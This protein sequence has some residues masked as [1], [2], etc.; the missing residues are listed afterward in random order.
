[1]DT[2]WSDSPRL[3]RRSRHLQWLSLH[4]RQRMPNKRSQ[5]WRLS[6]RLMLIIYWYRS[7][8]K[9]RSIDIEWYRS[10]FGLFI[11]D[12]GENGFPSKY[13]SDANWTVQKHPG[14]DE[15]G[16]SPQLQMLLVHSVLGFGRFGNHNA[17]QKLWANGRRR[18]DSSCS[19]FWLP[20]IM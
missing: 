4:D 14:W 17:K 3:P 9:L 16:V 7:L 15:E 19:K 20:F 11:S 18:V 12:C 8:K 10:L 6:R 13:F 2:D 5:R 1:M